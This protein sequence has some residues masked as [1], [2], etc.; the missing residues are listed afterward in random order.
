M[1]EKNPGTQRAGGLL[2]ARP[3]TGDQEIITPVLSNTQAES[4]D[5]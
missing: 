2:F 1:N 5:I 4:R 3:S